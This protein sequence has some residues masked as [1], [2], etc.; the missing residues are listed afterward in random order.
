MIYNIIDDYRLVIR[1][2]PGKL[3]TPADCI[4]GIVMYHKGVFGDT[5]VSRIIQI[6][7]GVIQTL[8]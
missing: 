1:I 3:F 5:D 8:S 6:V 7:I 2:V 4:G